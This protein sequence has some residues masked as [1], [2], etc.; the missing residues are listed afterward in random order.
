MQRSINKETPYNTQMA[1]FSAVLLFL[2]LAAIFVSGCIGSN[3]FF[4]LSG[5]GDVNGTDLNV[6]NLTVVHDT[7]L[8]NANVDNNFFWHG[9]LVDFNAA[10]T[11]LIP[12]EAE[13]GT[14]T[15]NDY[16]AFGNGAISRGV[17]LFAPATLAGITAVCETAGTNLGVS[18]YVNDANV[19][20]DVNVTAALTT[21]SDTC[22]VAVSQN[23]RI[24]IRA[25]TEVGAFLNCT[26]VAWLQRDLNVAGLKG[27]K[28]D[29]GAGGGISWA[30]ANA[31]FMPI[32]GDINLQIG[33][34]TLKVRHTTNGGVDYYMINQSSAQLV[35]GDVVAFKTATA[36]E[37][38]STTAREGSMMGVAQETIA[39]SASGWI[40]TY[41]WSIVQAAV[42]TTAGILENGTTIQTARNG[43]NWLEVGYQLGWSATS[44]SGGYVTAFI[45]STPVPANSAVP[46]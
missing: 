35:L 9:Q 12:F 39:T 2:L 13:R 40:R 23:S 14:I 46:P 16:W 20:C 25:L 37:D 26:G 15:S 7:N 8:H 3:K 41:G 18:I 6:S 27:E 32:A 44:V 30:D 19:G 42:G 31:N 22:N 4:M 43:L 17:G 11:Y 1:K 5:G 29:T 33:T 34:G 45:N 38:I 28:G 10:G 36:V 24:Q 21:A